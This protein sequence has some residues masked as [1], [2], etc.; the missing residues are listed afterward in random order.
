M[1]WGG[2]GV[3]PRDSEFYK[4]TTVVKQLAVGDVSLPVVNVNRS[5]FETIVRELIVDGASSQASAQ[6]GVDVATHTELS[7]CDVRPGAVCLRARVESC[8]RQGNT[9]AHR[10]RRHQ[11]AHAEDSAAYRQQSG[12]KS[13]VCR[14]HCTPRARRVA[15]LGV[16]SR[17]C[18]QHARLSAGE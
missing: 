2:V 14:P 6:R 3:G 5:L 13:S 7:P 4:T 9:H 12:S 8:L 16:R 1:G 15:V 17:R 11:K 10:A 18:S